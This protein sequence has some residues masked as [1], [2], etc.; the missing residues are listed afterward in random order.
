MAASRD[1]DQDIYQIREATLD[2]MDVLVRHRLAMFTDMGRPFDAPLISQMFRD[3]VRP[4]MIAGDY[5]A[6]LCETAAGEMAAPTHTTRC[7]V[8]STSTSSSRL[9]D[10]TRTRPRAVTETS[11]E[12]MGGTDARGAGIGSTP[13]R[14]VAIWIGE[15]A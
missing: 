12:P 1:V 3:W 15:L 5:R 9:L 6:W 14:T 8:A 13:A 10:V 2:D 11:V 7:A 4:M